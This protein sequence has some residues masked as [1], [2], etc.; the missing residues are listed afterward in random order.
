MMLELDPTT[1]PSVFKAARRTPVEQNRP[2]LVPRGGE[3]R[4]LTLFRGDRSACPRRHSQWSI[5]WPWHS[6]TIS[7]ETVRKRL[8]GGRL[9]LALGRNFTDYMHAI[10]VRILR[11]MHFSRYTLIC[12]YTQV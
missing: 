11:L 6:S 5:H 4:V 1:D 12:V 9:N 3:E 10:T 7:G 8:W 2:A